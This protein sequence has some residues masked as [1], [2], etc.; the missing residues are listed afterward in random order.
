MKTMIST[1]HLIAA[2]VIGAAFAAGYFTG[3]AF[4]EQTAEKRDPF[5]FRFSFSPEE[6]ASTSNAEK[7][8]NR[9]ESRVRDYCGANV[10][11]TLDQRKDV[12]ACIDATMQNSISKFGSDAVAQAY[13]SRADG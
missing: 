3:P 2:G 9:L 6:L 10:K 1:T 13:R 12:R 11:M 7:L 5:E 8:L 4:A